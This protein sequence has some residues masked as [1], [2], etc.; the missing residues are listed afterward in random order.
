MFNVLSACPSPEL[1]KGCVLHVF[2][3]L[4]SCSIP[5]I[6]VLIYLTLCLSFGL[7]MTVNEDE[8]NFSSLFLKTD[9][10]K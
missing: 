1:N 10:A 5:L 9:N 3:S 2:L 4:N 6:S 7:L 8:T